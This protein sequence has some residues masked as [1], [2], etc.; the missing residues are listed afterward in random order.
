M[1]GFRVYQNDSNMIVFE[2]SFPNG[3]GP[4]TSSV[5]GNKVA[6]P[7]LKAG[8]NMD[9]CRIVA[10]SFQLTPSANGYTAYTPSEGGKFDTHVHTY[11]NDN[12]HW[13]YS[14]DEGNLTSCMAKCTALKCTCFD[15]REN[16]PPPP[17]PGKLS[18]RTVFPGFKGNAA[19]SANLDCFSYN[20][21]FPA[22]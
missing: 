10:D 15:Y 19:P 12:H 8:S 11:C 6:G 14:T 13:A 2:Q 4:S 18:A 22:M 20:G 1:T 5:L 7:R 16:A 9:R 21:L 17:P 3:R